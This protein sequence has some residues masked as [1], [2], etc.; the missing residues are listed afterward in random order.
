M[1]NSDQNNSLTHFRFAIV[2]VMSLAVM[3]LD[4]RSKIL[5]DF[6]FYV[7]SA[8]V[9]AEIALTN[10]LLSITGI[11]QLGSVSNSTLE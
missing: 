11:E 3:A 8:L 5:T 7:E 6:R 10:D 4:V 2:L 9:P 1:K